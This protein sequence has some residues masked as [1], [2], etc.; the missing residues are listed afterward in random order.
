MSKRH[1]LFLCFIFRLKD[2]HKPM[3]LPVTS[4]FHIIQLLSLWRFGGRARVLQILCPRIVPESVIQYQ[5][6]LEAFRG[7]LTSCHHRLREWKRPDY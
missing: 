5:Y 4:S 3:L 1:R 7:S 6:I 2:G